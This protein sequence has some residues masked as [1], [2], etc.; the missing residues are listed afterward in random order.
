MTLQSVLSHPVHFQGLFCFRGH[1]INTSIDFDALSFPKS[2]PKKYPSKLS[3]IWSHKNYCDTYSRSPPIKSRWEKR[4]S[5]AYATAAAKKP[6][7]KSTFIVL[8]KLEFSRKRRPQECLEHLIPLMTKH[9]LVTHAF[10][11]LKDF[12]FQQPGEERL[13]RSIW[14][15][16]RNRCVSVHFTFLA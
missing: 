16:S 10:E 14:N 5:N 4:V 3:N 2:F 12:W 9:I 8:C 15:K 6:A 11:H 7:D 1:L 13:S